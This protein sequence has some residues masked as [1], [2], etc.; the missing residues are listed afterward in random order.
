MDEIKNRGEEAENNFLSGLN[1]AQSVVLAFKDLIDADE[2]TLLKMTSSFGGGI[3]RL[4][5]VCGAFS[6]ICLVAGYLRGYTQTNGVSKAEHYEFIRK[7]A[8]RFKE[9]NG[10]YIC[11]ELLG[12]SGEKLSSENPSER[13]KEYIQKR[14]CKKIC[15]V[16]AEILNEELKV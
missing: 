11:R 14:P 1:C 13:T 4:R 10:S 8:E 16:A 5:E 2:E 15:K 7:L 12:V 3:A 9:E 6:G